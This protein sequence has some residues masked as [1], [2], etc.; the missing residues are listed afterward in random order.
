MEFV[1][2]FEVQP[3]VAGYTEYL[4]IA[5]ELRPQLDRIAGFIS[6][7]RSRSRRGG[8]RILSL[9]YWQTEEAVAA[10][11]AHAGHHEAQLLGR[12]ELFEDYRLRVAREMA[13]VN[14]DRPELLGIVRVEGVK[15]AAVERVC[16]ELGLTTE[17]YDSLFEAGRS[18]VI[19]DLGNQERERSLRKQLE[20]EVELRM[21]EIERDYGRFSRKH[22]PQVMPGISKDGWPANPIEA[23][24]HRDPYPY[25]AD[26]AANRP[27]YR[28]EGL[29]M[30]VVTGGA[31]VKAA[32]SNRDMR[33]RPSAEPVPRWLTGSSAGRIFAGLMRMN[34]GARHQSRREE[35]A[36]WFGLDPTAAV[37]N[38]PR[39]SVGSNV[40]EFAFR[41]PVFVVGRLLGL[42]EE[43]LPEAVHMV[44][45]LVRC[46]AAGAS[47][48]VIA[49]GNAAAGALIDL[50]GGG[51]LDA[52]VANRIGFL[53][54][55]YEATAG[56][57]GNSLVMMSRRPDLSVA[58]AVEEAARWD[59]SVQNTRRFAARD[60]VVAGERVREGEAVLVVLAVG[61]GFGA[62]VHA[63]PGERLAKCIASAAVEKLRAAGVNSQVTGY[64]AS[65]NL[66]VPVW[67]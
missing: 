38:G 61:L 40:M 31:A 4:R 30:W 65:G 3:T 57:I 23:V 53:T 19:V 55:S 9:S 28:D 60:T 36:A 64:R 6:I 56:L 50:V 27:V 62:G 14:L 29:G 33:V 66:R 11:R 34:D 10:W 52:V 45:A 1:V 43:R 51:E 46:F 47:G 5:G 16:E 49:R 15:A 35:S 32:L 17:V 59:P 8:R 41:F 63:C 24:T 18:F 39:F 12:A 20:P 21:F 48:E 7:E 58:A 22:A 37:K 67:G 44:D 54:Q 42:P 2:C 13:A 25:Y 26:L